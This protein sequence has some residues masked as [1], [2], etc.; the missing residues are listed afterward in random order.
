[1]DGANSMIKVRSANA[2]YYLATTFALGDL[3]S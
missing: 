1:M 3:A 2:S